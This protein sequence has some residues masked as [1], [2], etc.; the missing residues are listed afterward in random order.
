MLIVISPAKNL[1]KPTLNNK[2][3]SE[4]E[5][6]KESSELMKVLKN[7]KPEELSKLMKISPKLSELNYERN[8][9]WNYP[10]IS[11][12]K[13]LALHMFQGEVFRGIDIDSFTEED[14]S[15][16]QEHLRILSGLYGLIKPADIILPY[17]LEMG[18]KL[19]NNKGKNLYEFWGNKI[20]EKLNEH[21]KKQGDDILINLASNEYFKAIK[22]RFLKAEIIT[23]IFKEEKNG[24]YKTIAIYAK[25]ARG[26][27][28]RFIIK[29]RLNNPED[30]KIFNEENYSYN[31]ELSSKNKLI[32]VR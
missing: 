21:I 15:F 22:P 32:F 30:I 31:E 13:G 9:K 17:R 10:F 28:T 27:M 7:F 2:I 20:T 29:N 16:A 3:N 11:T 5:F 4:I 6:P 26:M 23:P 18:T 14:F 12:E 25:K 19:E 24:E 1:G 8:L